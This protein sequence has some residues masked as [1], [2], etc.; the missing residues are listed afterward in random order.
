MEL[1]Q[2]KMYVTNGI[3]IMVDFKFGGGVSGLFIRECCRLSLEV[4]EQ[5]QE[6]ANLQKINPAAC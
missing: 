3:E 5:S 6:F 2:N 4:L 1:N